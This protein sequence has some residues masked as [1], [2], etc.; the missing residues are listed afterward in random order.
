MIECSEIQHWLV[1]YV[2]DE[3]DPRQESLLTEH[4]RTC[5]A[6]RSELAALEKTRTT[7]GAWPAPGTE[8]SWAFDQ[9]KRPW[10]SVLNTAWHKKPHNGRQLAFGFAFVCMLLLTTMAVFN[11][12]IQYEY[13]HWQLSMSL[14]KPTTADLPADGVVMTRRQL[15]E[16]EIKHLQFM[17]SLVTQSEGRQQQ[18]LNKAIANLAQQVD[19]KRLQDLKVVSA[20]LEALQDHTATRLAMTD[21]ILTE[22]IKANYNEHIQ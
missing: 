2:Y 8:P 3:L 11:A 15:Y 12:R 5:A 13:G 16:F 21:Q 14:S 19:Q 1:D 18:I 10:W 6:C 7:L 4:L 20:G 17:Q 9:P 22:F